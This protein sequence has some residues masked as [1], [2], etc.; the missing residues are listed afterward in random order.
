MK[1]T[2]LYDDLQLNNNIKDLA[3]TTSILTL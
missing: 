2:K 1:T 3:N